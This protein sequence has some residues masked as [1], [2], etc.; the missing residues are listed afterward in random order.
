MQAL[1]KIFMI[2]ILFLLTSCVWRSEEYQNFYAHLKQ[3]HHHS[4]LKMQEEDY[5]LIILVEARHLDYTQ[6]RKFFQ[7]I[8]KH[9]NDGT[10]TGDVGH[11]WIYLQGWTNGQLI[12]IEGGHS[13]EIAE[14]P[15]RYFDGIMNYN[16]WGYA[17]PTSKQR[18]SPRYEPNPIKYLRT[19][20]K[21]G[22]FQEGAGGHRP[23]FAAKISLSEQQF[24]RILT[25]INTQYNYSYYALTGQQCCSFVAQIADL[26]DLS[27]TSQTTMAIESTVWYGGR[28]IRLWEDPYY[29]VITFA[30]PDVIERSLIEAVEE[31]KAEYALDWYLHKNRFKGSTKSLSLN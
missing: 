18:Q 6:T 11:A 29:S 9:P 25:F 19:V 26:A 21:D 10:K 20:R 22:F 15:P 5:F 3:L 27:L 7:S 30:T 1:I 14:Q 31:G 23:T 13:G 8:A 24:K 4:W 12:A 16:D 2:G 17:N 28:W